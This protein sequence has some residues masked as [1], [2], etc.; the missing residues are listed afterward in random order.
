MAEMCL[1]CYNK[2]AIKNGGK[3]LTEE[4]VVLD[5]DFCEW[6]GEIKPC[7]I[8]IKQ[9]PKKKKSIFDFFRRR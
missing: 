3:P 1:D 5:D 2:D 9:Q 8:T 7:I 4:E 6:C